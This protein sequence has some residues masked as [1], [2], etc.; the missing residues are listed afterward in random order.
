MALKPVDETKLLI[1]RFDDDERIKKDG[2]RIEKTLQI[3][4]KV[5]KLR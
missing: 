2:D 1:E 4:K 5:L 3:M